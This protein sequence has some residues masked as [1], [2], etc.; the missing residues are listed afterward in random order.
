M[1]KETIIK[2]TFK[3]KTD[4]ISI[5]MFE[6][7][8]LGIKTY[9]GHFEFGLKML[10][11]ISSSDKIKAATNFLSNIHGSL[12]ISSF[13]QSTSK[14]VTGEINLPTIEMPVT[15]FTAYEFSVFMFYKVQAIL[16][17]S[18]ELTSFKFVSQVPM[19]VE[20]ELDI[21]SLNKENPLVDE[22]SWTSAI[23]EVLG[24]DLDEGEEI[25]MA[26]PWW[27]R[28]TGE[29]RDFFNNID[30][31][32]EDELSRLVAYNIDLGVDMEEINKQA[33]ILEEDISL[34]NKILTEY[35]ESGEIPRELLEE[36]QELADSLGFDLQEA[37]ESI[38]DGSMFGDY[39]DSE[40][41]IRNTIMDR[42]KKVKGIDVS[43]DS[44]GDD[45]SDKS[46]DDGDDEPPKSGPTIVRL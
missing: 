20:V 24:Q 38:S 6:D 32:T 40:G 5:L 33:E 13:S 39:D 7:D 3:Y 9:V 37:L 30:D 34:A 29:L 22:E 43:D 11:G 16:G 42:M 19:D 1:K 28:P 41:T 21:N 18:I 26:N 2:S 45:P 10:Y 12:A 27:K 8:V 15:H 35:K 4:P 23:N 44:S 31:L 14:F 25:V 46:E 17:E 36:I